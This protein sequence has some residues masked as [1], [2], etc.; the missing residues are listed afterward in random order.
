MPRLGLLILVIF[1]VSQMRIELMRFHLHDYQQYFSMILAVFLAFSDRVRLRAL[2]AQPVKKR[3]RQTVMQ[4]AV[5]H[6][7]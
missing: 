3:R 4:T 6:R 5:Y 1:L 7:P 2:Q